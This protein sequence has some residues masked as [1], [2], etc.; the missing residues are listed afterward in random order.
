M[1]RTLQLLL[2]ALIPSWE[3]FKAVAPSPRIEYWVQ[4]DGP[5]WR[6]FQP[7][8]LQLSPF[9]MLRRMFWN[10]DWNDQLF[11]VSCA[12]RLVTE[13]TEH[14]VEMIK[15]RLVQALMKSS[16]GQT[17]QFRLVFVSEAQ[18]RA[19]REVEYESDLF[20]VPAS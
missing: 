3:F 20:L 19:V 7:R 9:V 15:S 18:G 4:E 5:Y 1:L 14:S 13:P 8:P 11:L 17:V 2:P 12:E 10:P 16:A 6:E